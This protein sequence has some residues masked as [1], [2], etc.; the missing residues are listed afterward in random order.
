MGEKIKDLKEV[1]LGKNTLMLEKNK[2]THGDYK[3]DIH[4]QNSEFRLN[5]TEKD[6]CR[7]ACAILFANENICFY[8]NRDQGEDYE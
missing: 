4:L 5:M 8:K 6:F 2:G 7:M 1:Q 3:F